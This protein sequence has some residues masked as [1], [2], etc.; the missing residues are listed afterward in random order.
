MKLLVCSLSE[1]HVRTKEIGRYIRWGEKSHKDSNGNEY[2]KF[3]L[4]PTCKT[5]PCWWNLGEKNFADFLWFKAFNDR[6][7]VIANINHLPSSD[8]FYSIFLHDEYKNFFDSASIALNNTI[9]HLFTELNG[10]I[11]LGEGALDN[12]TYETGRISVV[13]LS[14]LYNKKSRVER[15]IK[16]AFEECGIDPS[17]PIRSQEPNPLPDRK[18]LDDIIFEELGLTEE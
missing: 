6:F 16:S 5:R 2:R 10:R 15:E 14:L 11:N 17:K 9:S 1:E 8:R 12:M 18:E 4:R 3:H 7:L 13:D